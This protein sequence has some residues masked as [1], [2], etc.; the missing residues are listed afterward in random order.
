MSS[1]PKTTSVLP[2]SSQM[3]VDT[4]T[5]PFAALTSFP[6]TVALPESLTRSRSAILL[7]IVAVTTTVA[8]GSSTSYSPS[9]PSSCLPFTL[10]TKS[11]RSSISS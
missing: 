5:V 3:A 6:S 7:S 10:T 1:V 4:D 9:L 8:K 2:S 11:T